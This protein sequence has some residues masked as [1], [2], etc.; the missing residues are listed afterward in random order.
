[1]SAKK[2]A[3]FGGRIS[4]VLVSAGSAIGLGNI[5]RFPYLAGENGGA[6]FLLFYVLAILL[7]GLPLMLAE[8][9]VGTA[10]RSSA[11][12]AYRKLGKRWS[13][14]GY[15]GV[16][17]AVIILGFYLVVAGWTA[18]YTVA[19]LTGELMAQPNA[20]AHAAAFQNFISHPWRPLL[21]AVLFALATHLIIALGVQKGIER[22]SKVMMPLL[23][24]FM[25]VLA[26]RSCTLDGGMEGLRFF[27]MPDL[28]KVSAS[29]IL[30]A[31]GQAFF[32][33][34]IGLGTMVVYA[35]YFAPKT[36]L[37]RTAVEVSILDTLVAVLAGLVIFPAVFSAGIEP[38][39]GPSL[40]FITLPSIFSKMAFGGVWATIFFLLLVL[41]ALTSTIS[42]HESFTAYLVDD[43]KLK[44]KT[45]AY[46]TTG[47][48]IVL[49][50][51]ASLSLGDWSGVKLFGMTI[52]D[53]MDYIT[54]NIMLPAGALL[55]CLF[56][57]WR[58]DKQL[59]TEQLYPETHPNKWVMGY[60]RLMWRVGSPLLLVLIFLDSLGFI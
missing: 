57:G 48:A 41:A 25:V 32:S 9:S 37:Q 39:S 20:E 44:R 11:V 46:L 17:T 14:V 38:G 30:A 5:W 60:L 16:L 10:T 29:T 6:A 53:A 36:D 4:A 23:L 51:V 58:M 33:L 3:T 15:I 56:V 8:F 55:A 31:V 22:S 42:M 34:S 40:V 43:W 19:S 27:L 7:I 21:Y 26:I 52:F 13:I 35:S 18:E 45:A 59:V 54:A 28:T 12:A 47:V 50:V 24:L 2:R 1:M 49:S